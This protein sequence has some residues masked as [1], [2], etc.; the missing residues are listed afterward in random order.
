MKKIL[1]YGIVLFVSIILGINISS[2]NCKASEGLQFQI[3]SV[4]W[5]SVTVTV[6]FPSDSTYNDI[7]IGDVSSNTGAVRLY[8][9]PQKGV[10]TFR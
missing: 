7:E 9:H 4:S 2:N 1:Q 8:K 6:N 10:G 3:R 5:N